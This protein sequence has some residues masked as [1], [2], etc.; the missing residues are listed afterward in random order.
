VVCGFAV[1][2]L[3]EDLAK[4]PDEISFVAAPVAVRV[5]RRDSMRRC[6]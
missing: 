4:S 5:G 1:V 6:E 3:R 2:V